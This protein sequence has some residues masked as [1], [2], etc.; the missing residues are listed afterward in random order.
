VQA[1]GIRRTLQNVRPRADQP[2]QRMQLVQ[3]NWFLEHGLLQADPKTARLS[4]QYER[5]LEVVSGLLQEVLAL[6]HAGDKAATAKFFERWSAWTP[7]LHD[8]LAARVREAQGARFRL[9]RY[10]A[11]GE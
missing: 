5:Y 3:F 6:Q 11:L 9:V 7:E 4:I 2:Y 10:G 8:T 1:S